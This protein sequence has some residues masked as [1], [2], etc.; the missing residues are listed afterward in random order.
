MNT[1][2]AASKSVTVNKLLTDAYGK[3]QWTPGLG[4]V[5]ELIYT[6][7]SQNTTS[8]NCRR[9][10]DAAKTRFPAWEEALLTDPSDLENAIKPAG[11]W[12]SKAASIRAALEEL[13]ARSAKPQ[14]EWLADLSDK[15]AVGFLMGI[16]GV[17]RKTA[18][19]VLM[20]GMGRPVLAVDTHV[21]RVSIR[22]GLIPETTLDKAHD[23]L[24]ES[25]PPEIVYE[26]HVNMVRHGREVCHARKPACPACVLRAE[27]DFDVRQGQTDRQ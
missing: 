16:P 15:D 20:F 21:R 23:L 1:P 22:L 18:A 11:L 4:L 19:C 9:A 5:D 14:L 12:R 2:N 7:L 13:G 26:F 27:C 25:V 10:F 6:I 3:V 24:A 17:G 8:A